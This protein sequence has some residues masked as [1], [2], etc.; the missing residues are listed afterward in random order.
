MK[1]YV[2]CL[3]EGIDVLEGPILGISGAPV[4]VL[5]TEDLSMLVSDLD[6]D[7]VLV[8]SE[9][10]LTHAAV[11]RSVLDRTTPLPFRFGTVVTELQL[12]GYLSTHKMALE[13]KL[14][15]VRG[16]VEMSIKIIWENFVAQQPQSQDKTQA[17]EQGAG[18]MFLAEKRLRIL[19]DEHRAAEASKISTWLHETLSE[20]LG[21]E[22]VTLRPADRLVVSAAHLIERGQIGQYREKVAEMRRNRPDLHF[23]S[24]GP[25]PPYSFANIGLEFKTQFGVS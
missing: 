2:Y 25:W 7:S 8:T 3:V 13:S 20:L 18:T 5:K 11:V 4:R 1:L 14:E 15:S 22:H 9:N 19:G 17:G 16:S 21:D 6:A 10:A 24:S 23:L 12:Q